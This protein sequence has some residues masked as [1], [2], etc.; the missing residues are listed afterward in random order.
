M[1]IDKKC[2]SFKLAQKMKKLGFNYEIENYWVIPKYRSKT[3]Y[4]ATGGLARA[5][6]IDLELNRREGFEEVYLAPD[7]I[8]LLAIL[9]K[10]F[11][12]DDL[13]LNIDF[14]NEEIF[15]IN[16]INVHTDITEYSTQ[17]KSFIDALAEMWCLLKE[18]GII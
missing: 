4:L 1:Q 18:K 6:R 5:I 15:C 14:E 9:P 3:A 17:N 12:Q 13:H 10:A 2:V 16:Y 7:V 8:E 11:N